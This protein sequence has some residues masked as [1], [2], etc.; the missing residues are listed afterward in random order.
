MRNKTQKQEGQDGPGLL[1]RN[2]EISLANLFFVA[3]REEFTRISLC[4]YSASSPHSL[5][6][7]LL[8]DQNFVNN[9]K[10]VTQ[11]TLLWNYFKI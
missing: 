9:F 2:F 1:T 3:F 10:K 5:I 8:T 11:G 4:L 7:C 6:P